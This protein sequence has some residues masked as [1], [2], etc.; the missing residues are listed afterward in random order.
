[1]QIENIRAILIRIIMKTITFTVN[2]EKLEHLSKISERLGLPVEELIR[3]SI[4]ELLAHPNETFEKTLD[5]LLKKN[6]ELYR[7]LT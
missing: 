6:A 7:R 3:L 4:E 2:D 1:M 5:Y